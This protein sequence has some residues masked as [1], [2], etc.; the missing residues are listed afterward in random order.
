MVVPVASNL[1]DAQADPPIGVSAAKAAAVSPGSVLV[2]VIGPG[3][4]PVVAAGSSPEVRR[5]VKRNTL[6][7]F[8]C[9][10]RPASS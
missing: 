8:R 2:T 3:D 1:G 4:G 10:I 5:A 9:W 7:Y 6:D